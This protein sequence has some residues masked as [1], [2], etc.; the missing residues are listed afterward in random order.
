[1]DERLLGRGRGGF[2]ESQGGGWPWLWKELGDK[3][4]A[5]LLHLAKGLGQQGIVEGQG[6]TD[7]RD[8]GRQEP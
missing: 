6:S 4:V 2:T 5:V 8:G 7:K 3:A 1:M